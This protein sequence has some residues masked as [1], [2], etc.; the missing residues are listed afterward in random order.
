[1]HFHGRAKL[2]IFIMC[3]LG[4]MSS[5]DVVKAGVLAWGLDDQGQ[6]GLNR[7]LYLT[8]PVVIN[9][10]GVLAS[11]QVIRVVDGYDHALALTADGLLFAWGDNSKGQLGNG[12]TLSENRPVPVA[13]AA[14]G[15]KK[16]VG[17][18][19]GWDFSVA[20]TD[21]GAVYA[22]GRSEDGECGQFTPSV[23]RPRLINTGALTGQT[24]TKVSA[25]TRSILALTSTAELV[26]WGYNRS[27]QLGNGL[28]TDSEVPV[29]ICTGTALEG[30]EIRD[31][32]AGNFHALAV[33]AD[34][35]VFSWGSTTVLGRAGDNLV[36]GPVDMSGALAGK[37][38]CQVTAGYAHSV[39]LTEDNL[40]YAWGDNYF[41]TY[42]GDPSLTDDWS[43]VP[44]AVRMEEFGTRQIVQIAAG[45]NHSM[46][47]TDDGTLFAWG[48]GGLGQFGNGHRGSA[49][50]PVESFP[51]GARSG[52][53]ISRLCEDLNERTIHVLTTDGKLLGWGTDHQGQVGHG[54]HAWRS[55][56]ADLMP[57]MYEEPTRLDASSKGPV[58]EFTSSYPQC[59][60]PSSM[61]VYPYF[62]S[63]SPTT[64]LTGQEASTQVAAGTDHLL[65]LSSGNSLKSFGSNAYGQYGDGTNEVYQNSV[66]VLTSGVLAGKSISQVYVGAHFSLVLT[67]NGGLYSWGRNNRGQ[68]GNGTAPNSNEPVAVDVSA[69]LAGKQS[70]ALAAGDDH[71]LCVTSDGGLYA[72]GANDRGQLGIGTTTDRPT[73]VEIPRTGE[74][75]G[76]TVTKVWAGSTHS[77]ALAS[78][79]RLFGWGSNDHGQLGI[80]TSSSPV[81]SP[82]VV[83]TE[84]AMLGK[85]VQKIA[86]GRDFTL[87]LCTDGSVFGMGDNGYGSLGTGDREDRDQPAALL[88]GRLYNGRTITDIA[89]TKSGYGAFALTKATGPSFAFSARRS[90]PPSY[91]QPRES[92]SDG[93]HQLGFNFT[94]EDATRHNLSISNLSSSPLSLSN[95][96][97]TGPDSALFS[98]SKPIPAT[99][100]A[101]SSLSFSVSATG[102]TYISQARTATLCIE[103]NDPAYPVYEMP[104]T[105]RMRQPRITVPA[106]PTTNVSV[107]LGFPIEVSTELSAPAD[108]YEWSFTPAGA[109]AESTGTISY[110]PS[111]QIVAA[112]MNHSGTY[113]LRVSPYSSN[114]YDV[115]RSFILT[116]LPTPLITA[117]PESIS[118]PVGGN[119][120]FSVEATS[121]SGDISYQWFHAGEPIQ[122]A[123]AATLTR[124]QALPAMAGDYE[125]R[126]TNTAGTIS[127]KKATLTVTLGAPLQ[128]VSFTDIAFAGEPAVL[129][130]GAY[131]AAP[132]LVQWSKSGKVIP[133]ATGLTYSPSAKM[134]TAAMGSYAFTMANALTP[135]PLASTTGWLGMMTRAPAAAS[136][137]NG[138]AISLNCTASSPA[139]TSISYEWRRSGQSLDGVTGVSGRLSKTLKISPASPDHTG[140]YVCHVTMT[141]P[142]GAVTRPNGS[143]TLTV[144]EVPSLDAASTILLPVRVG[145][146]VSH[147]LVGL[148]NPVTYTAT[149]LPTNITLNRSTGLLSGRPTAA[150]YAKGENVPYKVRITTINAA[151]STR[152]EE[153]DWLVLP[154]EDMT[155]GQ[156]YGLVDRMAAL[157]GLPG[158]DTG[159]GGFVSFTLNSS[160]SSSGTLMLGALKYT[161]PGVWTLSS[162]DAA[163]TMRLT[164]ARKTPLA[165]LEIAFTIEP[166]TGDLTGTIFAGSEQAAVTGHRM[167]PNPAFTGWWNM[168]LQSAGAPQSSRPYG[169]CMASIKLTAT[170]QA[171][172]SGKLADG[173]AFTATSGV[174]AEGDLP[175]HLLLYT[176]K[177]SFQSWSKLNLDSSWTGSGDWW[178][179]PNAG[180]ANYPQGF[181]LYSLYMTGEKYVIPGFGNLLGY[182]E[183][184]DNARLALNGGSLTVPLGQVFTLTY[185]HKMLTAANPNG[186]SLTLTPATGWFTGT[187]KS[188]DT[189]ARSGTLHGVMLPGFRIGAGFFLQALPAPADPAKPV[190]SGL[191]EIFQN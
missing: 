93:H 159:L 27:G 150:R 71:V 187:F 49:V 37:K 9:D 69:V 181:P 124:G 173:T 176:G 116:V 36:P 171:L 19:A 96:T 184:Y 143:T 91:N 33:T 22:W 104:V 183:S 68:L 152:T 95:A 101:G 67:T 157:N 134:N 20:W 86:A 151:G 164:I 52:R 114:D 53:T 75:A 182:A 90:A 42:L 5:M 35:R 55:E 144:I 60:F 43:N 30:L 44:R 132:L 80:G 13:M 172:W 168:I 165:N 99:L 7:S 51:A 85:T 179:S 188:T 149:G 167:T 17:I 12:S 177:G 15:T 73:P 178:K 139:G 77:F 39:A 58:L 130:S 107:N 6:L 170:G 142:Q 50:A 166:L 118:V 31:F 89:A 146:V 88:R 119:A 156:Y 46:A 72:W 137:V 98:L 3:L 158:S 62:P 115:T 155:V 103:T 10:S 122:G 24:V 87:I 65:F 162:V 129:V 21:D 117:Q 112:T 38:V 11:K 4:T 163:P 56:P 81:L 48:Y 94:N 84:D 186:V 79:G 70:I 66:P 92:F 110:R 174:G 161:L 83:F 54:S 135:T 109:S 125:V 45:V 128:M 74:L 127:S 59:L 78:D 160:G 133:G 191:V 57:E 26:G 100:A 145:Q 97:F 14:F 185:N 113:K 111:L 63:P 121:T 189:P 148:K 190:K 126:L 105:L 120:V 64:R 25:G 131:G 18:A 136:V 102:V 16:V 141:T 32:T 147:Q 106:L 140:A 8:N 61:R 23:L 41:Y 28:T 175:L 40:L 138:K 108:I 2:W 82:A 153:L 47:L 76:L 180:G 1:M 169:A 123:T 34:G 29:S 154:L